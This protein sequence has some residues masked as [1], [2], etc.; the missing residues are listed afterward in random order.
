MA[1]KLTLKQFCQRLVESGVMTAD[2]VLAFRA[3]YT[4]ESRPSTAD[5]M[6]RELILRQK[7]TPF[8]AGAL[9][10]GR[11]ERLVL[12]NNVLLEKIGEGGMGEVFKALHRRMRRLVCIKILRPS[13]VDSPYAVRRFQREVQAAAQLSHPH[14][15]TAFDADEEGGVHFLVMEYVEGLDLGTR[16]A[17]QGPLPVGDVIRYI[18]QAAIGLEYA[19]SKGIVH[20]DIKPGNLLLD[21]NGV[22]KVLDMGLARID[23]PPDVGSDPNVEAVESL[24][25]ENQIVGTV[26]YMSPEQA[27]DTGRV[28]RRSDIYSLGCTMFRLLAGYPPYQ[29]ESPIKVLMAHRLRDIPSLKAARPEVSAELE[30]IYLKMVAKSQVDR[31]QTM[32]EVLR[33]LQPLLGEAGGAATELSAPA[34][35]KGT[36][37]NLGAMTPTRTLTWVREENAR[38][39]ER[40]AE[41]V[42]SANAGETQGEDRDGSLER[43]PTRSR[44]PAVDPLQLAVGIDLG[45]TFS[46][47]AA[48]DDHGR[49]HAIVN[50][51]GDVI[52]P[53]FVL[54]DNA[55]VVVGKEAV[56]ALSVEAEMVAECAKRELG[57]PAFHKAFQGVVYPPEVLQAFVLNKLRQDAGRLIGDFRKVVITVPAYFDENRRKATE[58]AGYMAGFEVIDILNEPTAA[59]LAFGFQRG[60][61]RPDLKRDEAERILVYDLGGGTF[62]VTVMEIRGTEFVTLATDGD[63]RLGGRD[64][65]QRLVDY[66]AEQFVRNYGL[67]PREDANVVGRLWRDCEEAKRTLSARQKAHVVCDFRAQSLRVEVTRQL[68]HELTYD[69]VERT[70][71][72][73]RQAIQAAGLEWQEIDRVLLVGGSTRMPSIVDMLRRVTGKEPDN[74][75]APDEAVAHGAAL[76]AGLVLARRR[77]E[78]PTFSIRNVNSHSLGIVGTDSRTGRKQNAVII[79]RNTPLPVV[80]KRVFRTHKPGQTSL[81]LQIVEG[82]SVSPEECSAIGKCS[83]RGLPPNLPAQTPLEVRFHYAANGRITVSVVVPGYEQPFQQEISRERGLSREQLDQ[84]RA[85]ISGLPAEPESSVLGGVS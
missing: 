58:D 23:D 32:A 69:L 56:K 51:E 53:S 68:F 83:V 50:T 75:V 21:S 26:E 66:V 78:T 67:D 57:T 43:G 34:S 28:D 72:T 61:F 64:W 24:T 9:V 41:G 4:D 70:A 77:G 11:P 30:A 49:P 18:A 48:L 44:G 5:A 81:L 33:A 25:R 73:T 1:V 55:E 54:F 82:E 36:V 85:R 27:D 20:R 65:D 22:L 52:T 42:G 12:G 40:Q 31:Y 19:H 7:L 35:Q 3:G 6:A 59:A 60:Y 38:D 17:R 74:S 15:V 76:H 14:I 63:V 29:A 37:S 47:V 79:P 84:W 8:Q 2:E 62:D 13:L 71:F 80:A 10:S 46:V 45:T 39:T 16:V